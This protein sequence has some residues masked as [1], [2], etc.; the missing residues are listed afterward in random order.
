MNKF[1]FLEDKAIADIAFEAYGKNIGELFENCALAL[2]DSM[3][4]LKTVKAKIKKEI[5]L[6]NE[7]LEGL[8]YDFLSEIVYLKDVDYMVFNKVKINIKKNKKYEL[9]AVISGDTINQE[10]QELRN[11]VKAVTMHMFKIDKIKN[12]Y[13]ATIVIDI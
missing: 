7:N 5:T 6:D 1:K 9:K 12:N 11:D 3:A 10:K 13:K 2:F 4:N 8:L